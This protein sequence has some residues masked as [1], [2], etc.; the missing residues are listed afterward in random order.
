[1]SG[2][3]LI[4]ICCL[5]TLLGVG[6]LW[7]TLKPNQ[8][9]FNNVSTASPKT[10]VKEYS[11][12]KLWTKAKASTTALRALGQL[13][14]LSESAQIFEA[15]AR[16]IEQIGDASPLPFDQWPFFEAV[17]IDYGNRAASVEDL[18]ALALVAGQSNNPLTLREVAFRS[19]IENF[20]RMEDMGSAGADSQRGNETTATRGQD[21]LAPMGVTE[22][23]VDAGALRDAYALI[24]A[25]WGESNYLA[26]TALRA[27]DFLE[28]RGFKREGESLLL[29]RATAML[30]DESALVSNR[31]AAANV[32][33]RMNVPVDLTLLRE[34]FDV[35]NSE[36]S[37]V[38]LLQMMA[39]VSYS[40]EDLE[41]LEDFRPVTPEQ[42]RLVHAILSPKTQTGM[43]AHQER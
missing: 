41:W 34:A 40:K 29:E 12:D 3:L 24:D 28:Q 9:L 43:P 10:T 27:E 42:E 11:D 16:E 6:V 8:S 26:G 15:M 18:R 32:L 4:F 31:L 23:S 19:F 5:N 30:L 13:Q 22:E 20:S 39:A 1:M 7:F 14:K 36:R 37:Q 2:K 17:L 38:A 33:S 21:A 35:G 25:L